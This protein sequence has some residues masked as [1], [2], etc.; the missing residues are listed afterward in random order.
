MSIDKKDGEQIGKWIV[1][2]VL[3]I[4]LALWLEDIWDSVLPEQQAVLLVTLVVALL[5]IYR[6]K[7]VAIMK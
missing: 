7:V 3:A 6:K 5:L 2:F 4:I 1:P